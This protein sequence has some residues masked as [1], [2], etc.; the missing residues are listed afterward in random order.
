M[1]QPRREE[2]PFSGS[3]PPDIKAEQVGRRVQRPVR[4]ARNLA[5]T[6]QATALW[7]CS[8]DSSKDLRKAGHRIPA[9]EQDDGRLTP[10][11]HA[12]PGA[13]WRLPTFPGADRYT[14]VRRAQLSQAC[15]QLRTWPLRAAG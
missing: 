1:Q 7:A 2:P 15:L 8:L 6:D 4:I 9:T 14:A 10:W 11:D 13:D 12:I 5:T 3:S